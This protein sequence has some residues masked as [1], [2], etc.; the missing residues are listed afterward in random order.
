MHW[1][2]ENQMAFDNAQVGF[3]SILG[4]QAI[5]FHTTRGLY[6]FHD[7]K[8]S[9]QASGL[10]AAQASD[11]KLKIFAKWVKD[12]C[13]QIGETGIALYGIINR[14]EQY[15]P[16]AAGNADWK[17]VLLGLAGHLTFTGPVLGFRIN[18]HLEKKTSDKDKSVYVQFDLAG[19]ACSVG[20]KR[21]SKLEADVK[22][23]EK[24]ADQKIVVFRKPDFKGEDL[25]GKGEVAPV[26]RKDSSKG[27]NLNRIAIKQFIKIR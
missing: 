9:G 12:D 24:P 10:T 21:W 6:G 1:V 15:S 23:K 16:D 13:F 26:V 7:L 27:F 8:T 19:T 2:H 4:C 5:C 25:Y 11:A 18:N 14:D 20:F 3:P 17:S 22:N